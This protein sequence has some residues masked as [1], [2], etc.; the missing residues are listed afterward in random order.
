M[1]KIIITNNPLVK[2]NYKNH[3]RVE[4]EYYDLSYAEILQTV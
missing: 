1:K 3:D 4:V 2:E